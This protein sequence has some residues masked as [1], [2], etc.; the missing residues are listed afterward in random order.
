M[1]EHNKMLET[2]E[3]TTVPQGENLLLQTISRDVAKLAWLAGAYEGE[4]CFGMYICKGHKVKTNHGR[5][6]V[7]V[8]TVI[9][10]VNS[11]AR[12]IKKASEILFDFRVNFYFCLRKHQQ[13]RNMLELTVEGKGN[14]KK[15][16]GLLTPYLY[17]KLDQAKLMFDLIEYRQSRKEGNKSYDIMKDTRLL[18]SVESLKLLKSNLV[19]PSTTTRCASQPLGMKI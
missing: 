11:D 18:Q 9:T 17:S 5:D 7:Q 14:C 13:T 19:D 3:N 4:G 1:K 8:R 10:L 12:F 6:E 2:L 15:L 16:I